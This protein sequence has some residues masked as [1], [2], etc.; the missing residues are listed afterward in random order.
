MFLGPVLAIKFGILHFIGVSVAISYPFLRLR[1]TNLLLGIVLIGLGKILQQYAFAW[2]WL[3]W[4]G[5]EPKN[6]VYVDFFPVIS[7]FGVILIGIF[8]GNIL[9]ADNVR[10][11]SLPDL[12]HLPPVRLLQRL[13]QHS[14]T[15]YLVHQ[16]ILFA[17]LIPLL[18]LLGIGNVG[19]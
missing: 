10:R 18:W 19:F 9:Y 4:L 17:I 6:H 5:F 12:S 3:V 7:W 15:I 1:W 2:P 8:V 11:F 13:G 14:L 16:P